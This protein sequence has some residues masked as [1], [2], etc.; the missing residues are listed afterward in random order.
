MDTG[1]IVSD[2]IAVEMFLRLNACAPGAVAEEAAR[3]VEDLLGVSAR[4]WIL[5]FGMDRLYPVDDADPV[6]VIGSLLGRTILDRTIVRTESSCLVP[7]TARQHQVGVLELDASIDRSDDE[8]RWIGETLGS[9]IDLSERAS[10]R[11]P[12]LRGAAELQVAATIQHDML[13]M[14]THTG[15]VAEVAGRLEPAEDIAGDGFDY[16]IGLASIDMCVLDAAGH[17]LSPSL[18][19]LAAVG[20]YRKARRMGHALVDMDTMIEE[21]VRHVVGES[22]NF[23]S[24]VIVRIDL[25]AGN[26]QVMNAGHLQPVLIRDG[27]GSDLGTAGIN[28]PFGLSRH[29][30]SVEELPIEAGDVLAMFTD[31]ITESRDGE[32]NQ[33]GLERLRTMLAADVGAMSLERAVESVIGAVSQHVAGALSD[34]ATLILVRI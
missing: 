20:A 25:E 27:K 29:P 33:F 11:V 32:R 17:G 15:P 21:T 1:A 23:V 31:G 30:R 13:P 3:V 7:L 16:S 18:L 8:L 34:D 28:L 24:G 14:L 2:S 12:V 10:D 4:V 22:G 6:D 9:Q 19:T 26:L 5:G